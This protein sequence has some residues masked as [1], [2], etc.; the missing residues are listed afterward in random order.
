[1]LFH[2]PAIVFMD[3]ATSSLD[4]SLESRLLKDC[5]NRGISMISVCHRDSA[6]GYHHRMLRYTSQYT[7]SKELH[8]PTSWVV[9]PVPLDDLKIAT[10]RAQIAESE[11]Q[12]A[13]PKRKRIPKSV[14][15]Q[16]EEDSP[17]SRESEPES[18]WTI[19][20]LIMS[21]SFQSWKCLPA[22]CVYA[23]LVSDG[24]LIQ[25]I[26]YA[27]NQQGKM[28]LDMSQYGVT[29]E[30]DW[31]PLTYFF[32][33]TAGIFICIF[34]MCYASYMLAWHIRHVVTTYC[35]AAYFSPRV[36][37]A[38]NAVVKLSHVDQR[39]QQDLARLQI[40]LG[41]YGLIGL[42]IG[43]VLLGIYIYSMKVFWLVGVITITYCAAV[44]IPIWFIS[45]RVST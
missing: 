29:N 30:M 45:H 19:C 5:C 39:L 11:F 4:V 34:A 28:Q 8:D 20:K 6:L 9:S 31:S 44:S 36:M 37:Y 3:E 27:C 26:Y 38:L 14:C 15:D 42:N 32:F 43:F 2:G 33:Y 23:M 41:Q 22:C 12:N 40:T 17:E 25:M 13:V 21:I 35:H 7:G 18:G 24:C 1:M 10:K 16:A